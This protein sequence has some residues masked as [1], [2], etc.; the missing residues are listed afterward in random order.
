[1]EGRKYLSKEKRKLHSHSEEKN[2]KVNTSSGSHRKNQTRK[3][4]KQ[5]KNT[6]Q[7]HTPL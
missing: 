1:V 2:I 4:Q 7:K 6:H 3:T 5:T